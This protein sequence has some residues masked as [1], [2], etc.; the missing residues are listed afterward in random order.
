MTCHAWLAL[1]L[2]A[3][4]AGSALAGDAPAAP[5]PPAGPPAPG[6]AVVPQ[7]IMQD[8]R[9]G[10]G[11][12]ASPGMTLIVHYT[13][14]LFD[15]AAPEQKGSKFDSSRDRGR[16]F[17]FTLGAGRVIKGWDQGVAGMRLGGVRRLIIP[18]SLGYGARSVGNG[19]I[20]PD[21]T[22]LFEVELLG[23]GSSSVQQNSR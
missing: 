8:L 22:L 21:S 2:A 3:L 6:V 13:G 10:E 14:W 20:P 1:P 16:P 11:T 4:L 17:L 18:P 23:F 7:L 5:P 9:A 12:E 15:A 19:L